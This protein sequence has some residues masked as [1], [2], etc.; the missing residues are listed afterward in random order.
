MFT[1]SVHFDSV[2]HY[3]FCDFNGAQVPSHREIRRLFSESCLSTICKTQSL[4]KSGHRVRELFDTGVSSSPTTR[5]SGLV[6]GMTQL[7]AAF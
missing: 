5:R 3:V 7:T 4:E 2:H 6:Q 1:S